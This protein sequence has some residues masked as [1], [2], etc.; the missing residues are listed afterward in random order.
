M[1][2]ASDE[3]FS[4]ATKSLPNGGRMTRIACGRMTWRIDCHDDKPPDRA[5]SRFP[6]GIDPLP[7]REISGQEDPDPIP[8]PHGSRA[9][10]F[11]QPPA[12]GKS[13]PPGLRAKAT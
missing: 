6:R 7:A 1:T 11:R 3:S 5:A 12:P 10:L 8:H 13:T 4:M 2:E 9:V